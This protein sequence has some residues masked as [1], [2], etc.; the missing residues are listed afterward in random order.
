M[1]ETITLTMKE[2]R[3]HEAIKESLKGRIRVKEA[4]ML[5]GLSERQIYRLRR[6]VEK[7]DIE[8]VIHRLRGKS[9]S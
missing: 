5:L 8:G 9:F 3:K 4:A 1:K 6:R 2:Q 7:E